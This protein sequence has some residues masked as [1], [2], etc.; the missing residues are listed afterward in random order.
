MFLGTTSGGI[1]AGLEKEIAM[2]LWMGLIPQAGVAL[3][4][5][6]IIGHQFASTFGSSFQSTVIG[7][8]FIECLKNKCYDADIL[9]LFCEI[10]TY[11]YRAI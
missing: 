9:F 5:A 1:K 11:L 6:G 3:G 10:H 8:G 2:R 7:N 4:L